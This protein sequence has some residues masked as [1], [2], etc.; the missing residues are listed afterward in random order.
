MTTN[1]SK[2]RQKITAD[3]DAELDAAP[4][5]KRRHLERDE[6]LPL[7]CRLPAFI[8]W[9]ALG[10]GGKILYKQRTYIKGVHGMEEK[11]KEKRDGRQ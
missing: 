3:A 5:K 6:A 1:N 9:E 10:D 11:F 4:M 2:K 7:V 8:Q